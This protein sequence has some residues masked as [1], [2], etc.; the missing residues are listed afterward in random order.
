MSPWVI[1]LAAG[2]AVVLIVAVLLVVLV[3]LAARAA[4][5]AEAIVEALDRARDHTAPLWQLEQT[6]RALDRITAAGAAV[7]AHLTA[8]EAAS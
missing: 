2:G 4:A 6:L 8:K 3:S 1:G 7:R 5:K